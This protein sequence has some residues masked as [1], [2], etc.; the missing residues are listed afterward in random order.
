[1]D[2]IGCDDIAM[3][4]MLSST[5]EAFFSVLRLSYTGLGSSIVVEDMDLQKER[6]RKATRLKLL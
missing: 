5:S 4:A 6:L 1:M 2:A 3:R